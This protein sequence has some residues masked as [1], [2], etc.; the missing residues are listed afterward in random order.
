MIGVAV[1]VCFFM[2][3]PFIFASLPAFNQDGGSNAGLRL[4]LDRFIQGEPRASLPSLCSWIGSLRMLRCVERQTEAGLSL[5]QW[6]TLLTST[7]TFHV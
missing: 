7:S 3:F 1:A 2:F 5:A 4:E 6:L